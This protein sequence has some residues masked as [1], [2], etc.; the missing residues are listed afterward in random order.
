V[1]LLTEEYIKK[2]ATSETTFIKGLK[3]Y[4]TDNVLEVKKIDPY[5]KDSEDLY[6]KAR[7]LGTVKVYELNVK[8][9]ENGELISA[10]C[11]CP[12][13]YS[14]IGNCKH[15]TASLLYIKEHFYNDA[16]INEDLSQLVE[17]YKRKK[18]LNV[19]LIPGFVIDNDNVGIELKVGSD[20]PYVVKNIK[21]LFELI[22]NNAFFEY[23]KSL[24]FN[25]SFDVFNEKSRKLLKYIEEDAT[26]RDSNTTYY[27]TFDNKRILQL[28]EINFEKVL[29]LYQN[30]TLTLKLDNE[31]YLVK[32]SNEIPPLEF[33]FKDN[34]LALKDNDKIVLIKLKTTNYLLKNNTLY[35]FK[36]LKNNDLIPLFKQLLSS[37]Y[38]KI[39]DSNAGLFFTYIWPKIKNDILIDNKEQLESLNNLKDLSVKIYLDLKDNI[40]YLKYNF[41]YGDLDKETALL[42]G[43]FINELAENDFIEYIYELGFDKVNLSIEGDDQIFEFLTNKIEE[44]KTKAEVYVS[45][46]IKNISIKAMKRP[47]I[48]VKFD[49]NLLE[50]SLDNLD[51][52]INELE[53][54][55]KAYQIKKK[56]YRLKDGSILDLN[57][58]YVDILNETVDL[59][60]L[61]LKKIKEVNEV[62]FYKAIKLESILDNIKDNFPLR[63]FI[64]DLKNYQKQ[65]YK[66]TSQFDNVLRDYQKIGYKW[67][68]NLTKYHLGGILADDMG[69]G[70]TL[71]IITLIALDDSPLPSLIVSP[72]SLIYNW[73][74]E[75]KKFA[76]YVDNVVIEGNAVEREN[77]LKNY[78]Q[79]KVLITSYD[80][81][82][83]DIDLY[84]DLKFR[85]IVVDEAQN[86]KN[87]NTK[88]ALSV[89]SI[90]AEVRFALTGT[91]IE[92]TLADLWSIF[93]YVLPGYFKTYQA[94]KS[95]YE[96]E[97]V[98]NENKDMLTK[99]THQIA[100]FILRRTK[101]DVLSELPPKVEQIIYAKM[102]EEQSKVYQALLLNIKRKLNNPDTNKFVVLSYLTRLRQI[103]CDPHL[104]FDTYIGDSPKLELTIDLIKETSAANHKILVFSQF[105]TML[106]IIAK[107]LN[108]DNIKFLTLTG[109]TPTRLRPLLVD[110]FNNTDEASV[111]LISLKAGGL[112]LN[113]TGADTIIH[114]DPWW[115]IS[116]EN[117]AS[118]RA[119]RIGQTKTV[120]VMKIIMKD[121]VEEKII[122]L[123]ER[124]RDLIN[125][126]INDDDQLISKLSFSEIIS[127]FD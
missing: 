38:I 45:D 41:F 112:G 36:N 17:F 57:G 21:Y 90:N 46:A 98:K 67:L 31:N 103:C 84:K 23:G 101:K 92:N 91:P 9:K 104:I 6:F 35:S 81:L 120:Q 123:Q 28:G 80:Y 113:L 5:R 94:F 11:E 72:A 108:E 16:H 8:L 105:T 79:C 24:A 39:D 100:P 56:Y 83:R 50:V 107:R 102:D 32:Y 95:D 96:V 37:N 62:E 125:Q 30:Q 89:K 114:Y 34:R 29:E 110:Q 65:D 49:N 33:T 10:S 55:L 63:Q 25:H 76:S 116:A 44:L 40:L 85:Y 78:N 59:L 69:L 27:L 75:F 111:F 43:E 15:I 60:N 74:N 68:K 97:I 77:I 126:V 127:L 13:Y 109:D 20:H 82:K 54:V 117:Q 18:T 73:Q 53:R 61:P 93:D 47:S 118:D 64:N 122:K 14:S 66:L 42:K 87:Y 2:L 119:H 115:N 106:D 99:L 12:T 86:I 3:L 70:K 26:S 52:D 121:S 88:N 4:K 124:K 58:S 48:G 1:N 71:Q 51:F 22:K 7:V 19:N